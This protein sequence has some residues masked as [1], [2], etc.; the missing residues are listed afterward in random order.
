MGGA[1]DKCL[2][3][4]LDDL[5][6]K[7]KAA[8]QNKKKGRGSFNFETS[9]PTRTAKRGGRRNAPYG[10]GKGSMDMDE[11]E[12]G[13]SEKQLDQTL[14][15]IAASNRAKKGGSGRGRGRGKGKGKRQGRGGGGSTNGIPNVPEN[16]LLR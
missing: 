8:G 6:A 5:S 10:R 9:G 3:M 14:E 2:D 11:D 16:P 12:Q 1:M 4:S 15:D 13:G 7:S